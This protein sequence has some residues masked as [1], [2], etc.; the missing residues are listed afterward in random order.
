MQNDEGDRSETSTPISTTSSV[1]TTRSRDSAYRRRQLRRA[2]SRVSTKVGETSVSES[3]IPYNIQHQHTTF[4]HWCW[5]CRSR[6]CRLF[7]T[8]KVG[9]GWRWYNLFT[10]WNP[11]GSNA[12]RRWKPTVDLRWLIYA[13][14]TYAEDFQ[15]Y[16]EE[17][18]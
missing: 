16:C 8:A 6:Y 17:S 10:S 2:L 9:D 12:R 3:N 13:I 5:S 1:S 14:I 11:V 4:L 15:Y 7:V 18:R